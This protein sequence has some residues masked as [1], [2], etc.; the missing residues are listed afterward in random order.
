MSLWKDGRRVTPL[1]NGQV[2]SVSPRCLSFRSQLT[3]LSLDASEPF[4]AVA[5]ANADFLTTLKPLV[6]ERN[7]SLANMY[8]VFDY[9]NVNYIHNAQFRQSV[10]D[11]QMVR[12]PLA[13]PLLS[14]YRSLSGIGTSQGPCG[15]PRTSRLFFTYQGRDREYRG[16]D[17]FACHFGSDGKDR[18]RYASSC[19]AVYRYVLPPLIPCSKL[20]GFFKVSHISL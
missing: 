9:M 3:I 10:T 19:A 2:K 12:L 14:A 5:E 11:Q 13:S 7:V 18:V 8:N 15:L 17:D 20:I 1:R 16:A 6:G 4:K